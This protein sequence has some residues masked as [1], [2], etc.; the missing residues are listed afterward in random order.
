DGDR[1]KWSASCTLASRLYLRLTPA[2]P[3]FFI[4]R[5]GNLCYI[6]IGMFVCIAINIRV[7]D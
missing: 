1:R 4:T 2:S 6:Y 7:K 3:S 5:L